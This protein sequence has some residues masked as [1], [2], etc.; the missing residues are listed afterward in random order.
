MIVVVGLGTTGTRVCQR[1]PTEARMRRGHEL[2]LIDYDTVSEENIGTQYPKEFSGWRKVDAAREAWQP[3]AMVLHK[4]LDLTTAGLL[5]D[6]SIVIDCTDNLLARRV[7]NDYCGKNG[8]P[9]VHTA[10]SDTLGTVAL[11]VPG[12]A[13]FN[14]VY[15]ENIGEN[16]TR[17][18]NR[19]V[20]EHTAARAVLECFSAEHTPTSR[21]TRITQKDSSKLSVEQRSDCR[22]CKGLYS[23]LE[24]PA[25]DFYITY[26][27]NSGCMAAKPAVQRAHDHGTPEHKIVNGIPLEVFPNGEIHFHKQADDDVL[28][29]TAKEV[30]RKKT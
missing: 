18:F 20:A 27:I 8:I 26:C 24:L 6:A 16:C 25:G 3:E 22:T 9:W 5:K 30:Y 15:P 14:C 19:L 7:I 17:D 29:T 23:Y 11:F 12:S 28:Y 13:C 10:L 4:H 2:L 1:L 21:Y